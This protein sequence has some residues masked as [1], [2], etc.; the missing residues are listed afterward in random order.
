MARVRRPR[1]LCFFCEDFPLLDIPQLLRGDV[2]PVWARQVY[3]LS[4]L[5]GEAVPIEA[6]EF[7]LAATTPAS[8]WAEADD[9]DKAR[10]LALKG[11]L[12][13]DEDDDELALLRA[14]HEELERLGWN[15]EAAIYYFLTKWRGIDLRRLAGQD[16]A[17]DLLPPTDEAVRMFVER[18]GPPPAAF[19]STPAPVAVRELPLVERTG[20]LYDVLI[21][22]RTTRSF[23]RRTPL[24]LEELAVLL[25][26]VFGY[27]GYAP[28]FGEVTTLKRTSPSAGGFHPVEAYPLVTSVEGLDAGV[29]HYL[30]VA[31]L[32]EQ[33]R[34]AAVPRQLTTYLF[35][36]QPYVA[37]AAA[38]IVTT[39]VPARSL[40]KY[41]DR[42]YRYLLFEAG[43]VAQNINLAAAAIGLGAC[44]LGGFFD[45]ELAGLLTIDVEHELPIYAT[46]VGVPAGASKA[47]RRAITLAGADDQPSSSSS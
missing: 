3:A 14:R 41:G 2:A 28:L 8:D 9:Y 17:A 45:D 13:S 7:E 18:F 20:D 37:E 35:M 26:Y 23:D 34:D 1:Y 27:H 38:V 33:L 4:I 10:A 6:D 15:L 47:E 36:G 25:R 40:G 30:P 31:N 19:H 42:G 46:A 11:V 24:A 29:Y 5:R 16:E 22:R 44:N 39:A 43:H 12:L 21:R 32:L